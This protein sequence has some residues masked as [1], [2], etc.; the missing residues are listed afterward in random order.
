M[1][2]FRQGRFHLRQ[3]ARFQQLIRD[4]RILEYSDITGGVFVLLGGAEQL[5]GASLTAFILDTGGGTQRFQAVAAVLRQT[6]HPPFVFHVVRSVAVA[7]HL[8]HPLQL[9]L[10]AVE[11]DRQ[12]RMALEHPLNRLQRYARC[13]PRRRV[14]RRDLS[15]V[16]R[17]G[18]QCRTRF[19]IDDGYIMPGLT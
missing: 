3:L 5:Q 13:R 18:L 19:P 6:Y 8:P 4:A 16:R 2:D 14:A 17:A 1:R 15:G 11:T 10:G 12:R 9:E 7:Q